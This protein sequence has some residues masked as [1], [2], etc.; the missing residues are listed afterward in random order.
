MVRALRDRLPKEQ[1]IYLGDTARVPYGTKSPHVVRRYAMTC[2]RF[3]AQRNAKAIVIACNTASAV[4]VQTIRD[5]LDL[6][7]LGVIEPGARLAAAHGKCIGVIGTE[8]TIASGSYPR[9]IS[10]S[11]KSRVI[12][13][14]T[15][16]LVPLAEEGMVNHP[17]TYLLAKEYLAPLIA[18]GI[19]TLILG[20][21]HYPILRQVIADICGPTVTIIDSA[22]AVAL[23][24]EDLLGTEL[25][26]D[27]RTADDQFFATDVSHRVARVAREF[28]GAEIGNVELVDL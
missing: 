3:L 17:A 26:S 20:C 10:V 27:G 4:A 11:S 15:P 1:L 28:L 12:A 7:V 5:A 8:S 13:K 14:P 9:A 2:A 25:L 18:E 24:V 23:A 21:T 22:H 19:D 6:P 16:L